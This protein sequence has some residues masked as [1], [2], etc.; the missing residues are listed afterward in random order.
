MRQISTKLR[1]AT[2]SDGVLRLLYW[3]QGCED[4]HQVRVRPAG[5][6]SW[7]WD[8]NVE[9]PTF[10][11]S[12]LSTSGH[13]VPGFREGQG[14]WCA[15]TDGDDW[16][17]CVRCHTF[18]RGGMVEFLSDCT[19]ALAGQTLPLPDWPYADGEYGGVEHLGGADV[20]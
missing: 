8:G 3:C 20:P 11:P 14:C 9:A 16:P 4:T 5:S 18:I 1:R 19:H 13:Y 10:S 7:D 17:K 2:S 15:A 12:V 6:P